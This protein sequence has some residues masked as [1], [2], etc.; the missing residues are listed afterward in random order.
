MRRMLT[1]KLTKSIKEVVN[2]YNEGE[3]S[4]VTANPATTTETL[5]AI[6]INGTG[7]AVSGGSGSVDIDNKTIIKNENDELETAVGGYTETQTTT[8]TP[9]ALP[10]SGSDWD[11]VD[12]TLCNEY[13]AVLED[14]VHYPVEVTFAETTVPSPGIKSAEL[15]CDSTDSQYGYGNGSTL[16]ITDNNDNVHSWQFYIKNLS[17]GKNNIHVWP[18]DSWVSPTS[19]STLTIT[20]AAIT[21]ETIHTIDSKYITTEFRMTSNY[22]TL[23]ESQANFILHN[24]KTI[25]IILDNVRYKLKAIGDNT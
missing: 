10:G 15:Y 25:N 12:E 17:E 13:L 4:A 18:S 16:K 21:K 9:V 5:T 2:A 11:L 19:E 22:M 14:G 1:D 8:L 6:E 23:T 7:Y 24:I 20:P 3:F